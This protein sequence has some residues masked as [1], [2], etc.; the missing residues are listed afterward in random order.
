M[1]VPYMM[2]LPAAVCMPTDPGPLFERQGVVLCTVYRS[3]A[4]SQ[5]LSGVLPV[6]SVTWIQGLAVDSCCL[7]STWCATASQAAQCYTEHWRQKMRYAVHT[8]T[9]ATAVA[10]SGH[11]PSSLRQTPIHLIDETYT[12]TYTVL[13]M[14]SKQNVFSLL[15]QVWRPS[16]DTHPHHDTAHEMHLGAQNKYALRA[17]IQQHLSA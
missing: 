17:L 8:L 6:L 3:V 16:H 9:A 10:L 7:P 15:N 12:E 11:Q 13:C 4:C 14:L 1:L 2:N 5:L